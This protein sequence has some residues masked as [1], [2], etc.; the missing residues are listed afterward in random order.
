MTDIPAPTATTNCNTATDD[1]TSNLVFN[2]LAC[3]FKRF[4]CD[5]KSSACH[6]AA[7]RAFAS[8]YVAFQCCSAS[9]IQS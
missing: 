8:S 4:A 9:P 6:S 3:D 2:T 5:S 7:R 1:T